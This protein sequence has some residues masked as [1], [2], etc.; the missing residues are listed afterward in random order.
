MRRALSALVLTSIAALPAMAHASPPDPTWIVGVYDE[1][2]RDDLIALA[3]WATGATGALLDV[4]LRL[5]P[6][7]GLAPAHDPEPAGRATCPVRS[8]A[9]PAT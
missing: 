1:G 4:H 7:E 5:L 6:V 3:A 9:P 8:R 2:D